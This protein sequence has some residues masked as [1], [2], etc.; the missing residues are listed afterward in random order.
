MP[1]FVIV[2]TKIRFRLGRLQQ[3]EIYHPKSNPGK[4]C[5]RHVLPLA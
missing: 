3:E 2:E 5:A 1:L 4:L